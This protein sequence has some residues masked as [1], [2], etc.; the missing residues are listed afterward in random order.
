LW[1]W[2][3]RGL[4]DLLWLIFCKLLLLLVVVVGVDGD[5]DVGTD[6][7]SLKISAVPKRDPVDIFRL[8]TALMAAF[9]LCW[10]S[11]ISFVAGVLGDLHMQQRCDALKFS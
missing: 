5:V 8:T 4:D 10:F 11:K 6:A 7:P 2:A 3:I 9:W 1:I